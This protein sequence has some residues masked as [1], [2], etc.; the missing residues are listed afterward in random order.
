MK[1]DTTPQK[2]GKAGRPGGGAASQGSLSLD[3]TWAKRL[4]IPGLAWVGLLVL[5]ALLNGCPRFTAYYAA[6]LAVSLGLAAGEL[7]F[8]DALLRK[9]RSSLLPALKK[10]TGYGLVLHYVACALPRVDWADGGLI[11]PGRVVFLYLLCLLAL[12]AGTALFV[13]AG[14]PELHAQLGLISAEELA[15][16]KLRRKRRN[17]R[18]KGFVRNALEWVDALAFAAILVIVIDFFVFQLYVIP[19]ESMVPTF[20]NKDRPFTAKAIAGPRIPLTEWRLPFVRLPRR[21]D[22]VTI[23]NP[24][25]PE[26]ARVGLRKY[27]SQF[28]SMITFTAVNIDKLPDG[29]PK[30]DPLVKRVVGMP[31]EK[32]A[33]V[34][35]VLYAKRAGAS[36]A[37]VE[38]DAAW[39]RTDLWK[40]DGELRARIEEIPVDERGRAVL[41][42]WDRRK[43]EADLPALAAALAAKGERLAARAAALSPRI[44]AFEEREL[45]RAGRDLSARRDALAAAAAAGGQNA[46]SRE[47]AGADD[48]ALLLALGRSGP[49]REAFRAY[50]GGPAKAAPL[51]A[52]DAYGRGSRAL[53]LL[54][55]SNLVDRVERDLEL[56]ESAASLAAFDG[57]ARRKSLSGEARELYVYLYGF[58][59]ARNFPEFPAGAA[60]LGPTEYFAMGDN[61]Y[62]SLD[63]RFFESRPS[64]RA[65]DPGD[66]ASILYPSILSPFAL[67]LRYIEGYALFRAWPP[68]RVG[69]IR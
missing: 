57:D 39:S 48:L 53:D 4:Y 37:K 28:V 60:F 21:G 2:T 69:K 17:E 16:P 45:S 23:A 13:M 19:S 54:V 34:D 7:A 38:A 30:A 47:G 44:A 24:R 12:A 14:R 29:S 25:Y 32:L 22:V 20:L 36:W 55:K 66:P 62:N 63:F 8:L 26:N 52:D 41:E 42:S 6:F 27:L 56:L 61:R 3:S 58:Y 67:D 18:K 46:L 15:D 11:G 43:A 64:T 51:A 9:G 5:T 1:N 40:L 68:S 35:D 59:D 10:F 49:L 33:M 65:L 50:C 31:G